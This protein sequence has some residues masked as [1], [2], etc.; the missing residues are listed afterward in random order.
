MRGFGQYGRNGRAWI[1]WSL[2]MSKVK[3]TVVRDSLMAKKANDSLKPDL[4]LSNAVSPNAA[5]SHMPHGSG[6]NPDPSNTKRKSTKPEGAMIDNSEPTK[7]KA[8]AAKTTPDK[9]TTALAAADPVKPKTTTTP[10]WKNQLSRHNLN[11]TASA[12]PGAVQLSFASVLPHLQLSH[13]LDGLRRIAQLF[14]DFLRSL[15]CSTA[16]PIRWSLS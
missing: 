10:C 14:G 3:K 1:E 15:K 4:T 11:Q 13:L 16:I 9:N 2:T 7:S 8:V 5:L 6:S 12:K